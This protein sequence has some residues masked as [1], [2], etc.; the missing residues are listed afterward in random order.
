MKSFKGKTE[1]ELDQRED[2]DRKKAFIP[3][4]RV[5]MNKGTVVEEDNAYT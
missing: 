2:F 4:Q 1:I 3:R 5:S